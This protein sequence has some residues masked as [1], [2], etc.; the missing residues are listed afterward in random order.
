VKSHHHRA[1]SV[2]TFEEEIGNRKDDLQRQLVVGQ[3][4]EVRDHLVPRVDDFGRFIDFIFDVF[5]DLRRQKTETEKRR[6]S[7]RSTNVLRHSQSF[8]GTFCGFS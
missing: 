1:R 8:A 3:G 2:S 5:V 4:R 6:Q 7:R